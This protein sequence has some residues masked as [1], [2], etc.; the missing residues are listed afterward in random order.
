[1]I[2]VCNYMQEAMGTITIIQKFFLLF[3]S[4]VFLLIFIYG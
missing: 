4:A 1:M 2:T 3:H